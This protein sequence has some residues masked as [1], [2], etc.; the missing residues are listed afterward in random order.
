[1]MVL[2][3][4]QHQH[5]LFDLPLSLTCMILSSWLKLHDL[6]RL[7]RAVCNGTLR[8]A[9]LGAIADEK[10]SLYQYVM[11]SSQ[12]SRSIMR[13][14]FTLYSVNKQ[15]SVDNVSDNGFSSFLVWAFKRNV[16]LCKIICNDRKANSDWVHSQSV[17]H[18]CTPKLCGQLVTLQIVG[19][20]NVNASML[21]ALLQHSRSLQRFEYSYSSRS[22]SLNIADIGNI[23]SYCPQLRVISL[24][25]MKCMNE[26]FFYNVVGTCWLL[27]ECTILLGDD[28]PFGLHGT[29]SS[30]YHFR[31]VTTQP[32]SP[33]MEN[34]SINGAEFSVGFFEQYPDALKHLEKLEVTSVYFALPFLRDGS[35]LSTI[36]VARNDIR[37][38]EYEILFKRVEQRCSE[39]TS[40]HISRASAPAIL[41]LLVT[42]IKL[43]QLGINRL[44]V[45]QPAVNLSHILEAGNNLS[46]LS[47]KEII[48]PPS[49]EQ[50][51]SNLPSI[52]ANPYLQSL[53]LKLSK[54]LGEE[55]VRLLGQ[56]YPNVKTVFLKILSSQCLLEM[57][58]HWHRLSFIYLD[59]PVWG[60][61]DVLPT[62][63]QLISQC[64]STLV[65]L[66][67]GN[68]QRGGAEFIDALTMLPLPKLKRLK[69]INASED[70]AAGIINLFV[71]CSSLQEVYTLMCPALCHTLKEML[72]SPCGEGNCGDLT[73][74]SNV[75]WRVE[76]TTV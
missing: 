12:Q 4:Q 38:E 64:S 40:L 75:I 19:C 31:T 49:L 29:A 17:E 10:M 57:S 9:F 56:Y 22:G 66:M 50:P 51:L 46:N 37:S 18:C 61:V 2:G 42:N 74:D 70:C 24:C 65:M 20:Q 16:S 63:L 45:N 39:L 76:D 7:D 41:E 71:M 35:R 44:Y 68:M 26:S 62:M 60:E 73:V 55:D 25:G 67:L 59:G 15:S 47:L 48:M 34:S 23:G 58:N 1:M 69:I 52:C 30:T 27:R 13:F 14:M 11:P 3:T 54:P 21:R 33:N 5:L 43:R 8:K 72:Q 53:E 28:V 36:S 6:S 32:S